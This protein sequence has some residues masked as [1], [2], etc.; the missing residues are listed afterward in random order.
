MKDVFRV[1]RLLTLILAIVVIMA[2]ASAAA[3]ADGGG[4]VLPAEATPHGYSLAK[5]AGATAH[6]N[7]GPRTPDTL[8]QNFPF[9]ILYVP[10][11]G[12]TGNTFSVKA[13]TMFYVPLVYSDDTDA[14]YWAYPD[15][16]DPAAVSAYYFDPRQLGAESLRVEVDNKATELGPAY[17]VGAVTPGLP[18]GANNYTVAAAF[19]SPLS[20]GVHTVKISVRLTGAFIGGVYE[21]ASTYTI[22]VK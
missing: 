18:T 14:A 13:G 15:V 12:S 10:L 20:S 11:D 5:A 1:A 16:T 3:L 4:Q 6:F 17:A 21:F 8:P 22:V 9:Q 19:L 7:T 2:L